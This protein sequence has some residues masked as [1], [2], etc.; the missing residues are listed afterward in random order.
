MTEKTR[1]A[2]W[3]DP[4]KPLVIGDIKIP[5]YVLEDGTRVLSGRGMQSA[6]ALGQRHGA[7]LRRFIENNAIKPFIDNKL[8]MGLASPIRFIRPGRGGKLA[9]GYEATLLVDICETV[10]RARDNDA[11]RGAGQIAVAKQC[12][13]LTR[14]M[15]RIGIIALVDEVTGYVEVEKRELLQAILNKWIRDEW[16][17]WTKRFPDEFYKELF[18]LRNIPYPPQSMKRPQ[19]IGHWTNDMV[20]SRLAPGVLKALREKNPRQP[21]G[22]RSHRHHQFLTED[23]GIPELQNHLSNV[24]F[25]MKSCLNWEDFMKRLNRAST[26]Y[27][28]TLPVP[29]PDDVNNL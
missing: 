18:R 29:Y 21:F 3:G 14:G 11:L 19:Y 4:N 5:C 15:A 22:N 23:L 2:L 17:K 16:A 12:E 6:L 8:A 9:I 26:K 28:D 10:L 13:I 20:Y 25:L 1:K 7:L 27:G 24:I